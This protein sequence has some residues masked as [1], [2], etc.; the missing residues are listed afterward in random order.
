MPFFTKVF[1]LSMRFFYSIVLILCLSRAHAQNFTE[2]EVRISIEQLKQEQQ[3][4]KQNNN[5]S[6]SKKALLLSRFGLLKEAA[7]LLENQT[8]NSFDWLLAKAD[9]YTKIHQPN[10][11]LKLI[12]Q[13]LEAQPESRDALILKGNIYL[14]ILEFKKA[15]QVALNRLAIVD[16]DDKAL[17]IK[18]K[19][20]LHLGNLSQ[21]NNYAE[22]A[23]SVNKNNADAW[24]T[25]AL[26]EEKNRKDVLKSLEKCLQ[27]NPYHEA[28]RTKLA[29]LLINENQ[30]TA[31]LNCELA[32]LKSP[33]FAKAHEW[34][35][36]HYV[37][38]SDATSL[39]KINKNILLSKLD[40]AVG[41]TDTP[42]INKLR[43]AFLYGNVNQ[44]FI[45][46]A[47]EI[48]AATLKEASLHTTL[49]ELIYAAKALDR[50]EVQNLSKSIQVSDS[51]AI[52]TEMLYSE[53]LGLAIQSYL[54]LLELLKLSDELPEIVFIPTSKQEKPF[55]DILNAISNQNSL[56]AEFTTLVYQK[57]MPLSFQRKYRNLAAKC[58]KI[59]QD[60]ERDMQQI[61]SAKSA[62]EQCDSLNAYLN[63][64]I[65]ILQGKKNELSIFKAEALTVKANKYIEKNQFVEAEQWIQAALKEN[66]RYFAA[67]LSQSII[68]AALGKDEEAK[69]WWQTAAEAAAAESDVYKTAGLLSLIK[70]ENGKIAAEDAFNEISVA[71]A[72]AITLEKDALLFGKYNRAVQDILKLFGKYDE[73]LQ[74]A[75]IYLSKKVNNHLPFEKEFIDE[76]RAYSLSIRVAQGNGNQNLNSAKNLLKKQSEHQAIAYNMLWQA[77]RYNQQDTLLEAL[78]MKPI[79]GSSKISKGELPKIPTQI[80][81]YSKQHA[82][83][84]KVLALIENNE[85]EEADAYMKAVSFSKLPE[86]WSNYHYTRGMLFIAK[87]NYEEASEALLYSISAMPINFKSLAVLKDLREK[88]KNKQVR[89]SYKKGKRIVRKSN[90]NPGQDFDL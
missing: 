54:P 83:L 6:T 65:D 8:D 16:F 79:Y 25:K 56:L 72:K 44:N 60:F 31:L 35:L 45:A 59:E 40:K 77:Y 43:Y 19:A 30:S 3:L 23:L 82:Y 38:N 7:A 22:R 47:Q 66:P 74:L 57:Q 41:T 1:L 32:L 75:E 63:G 68:R 85:L 28:A 62:N 26:I 55:F 13:A 89:K 27:L 33:Y 53:V 64:L 87:G 11:A 58:H 76:T 70:F 86:I 4:I 78:S 48:H 80:N 73:G 34:L 10:K 15:S 12:N 51:Q 36:Q 71:Y 69:L 42:I 81:D 29:A 14:A 39:E 49:L 17:V 90:T 88:H 84:Q 67:L 20:E 52:G 21:A 2:K 18:A 61:L 24:Y 50:M 5:L 9:V 46:K 37:N